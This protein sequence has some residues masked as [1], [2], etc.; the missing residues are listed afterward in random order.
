MGTNTAHSIF[1]DLWGTSCRLRH[2]I[3]CWLLLHDRLNTRNML[4]WRSM[5]LPDYHCALCSDKVEETLNHLF[6]NWPFALSC[7][8]I[9]ASRRARGISTFDG[10]LLITNQLPKDLALDII[11]MSCSGIWSV[12]ND[13]IYQSA[14]PAIDSWK[15]YLAAGL[16]SV[17]LRAKDGKANRIKDWTDLYL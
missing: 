12:R 8:D 13:K 10:I 7:W 11:V 6:W 14:T 17:Q 3:F 1:P 2:K 4:H 5:Y 9:I 16:W 15:F